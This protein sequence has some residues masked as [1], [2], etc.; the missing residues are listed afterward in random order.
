MRTL[1]STAIS[2]T[3]A[4]VS[5]GYGNRRVVGRVRLFIADCPQRWVRVGTTEEKGE[6]L[7]SPAFP[8]LA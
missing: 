5:D 1:N 4:L 6:A 7:H 8:R 2:R 3:V